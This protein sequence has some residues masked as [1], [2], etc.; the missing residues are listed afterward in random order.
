MVDILLNENQ[1]LRV[2]NNDLMLGESDDQNI[3]DIL[4]SVK[5]DYKLTPQIGVD[6]ISLLNSNADVQGIKNI[7][8]LNLEIDGFAVNDVIVDEDNGNFKVTPICERK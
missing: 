5:G 1:S 7:V 4:I 6:A 8:R 2:V 3:Y